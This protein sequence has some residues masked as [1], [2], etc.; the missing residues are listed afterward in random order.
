MMHDTKQPDESSQEARASEVRK[1]VDDVLDRLNLDPEADNENESAEES[2]GGAASPKQD[3]GDDT[4]DTGRRLA[5]NKRKSTRSTRWKGGRHRVFGQ[6]G[7]GR[8]LVFKKH[9][10]KSPTSCAVP[11]TSD[12]IFHRGLYYQNGDIVS[13]GDAEDGC[14]YYAQIR[15]FLTTEY[16]EHFAALNWL[17]PTV[18]APADGSFHAAFFVMGPVEDVPRPLDSM[19]FEQHCAPDYFT[20]HY[21]LTGSVPSRTTG[22]LWTSLSPRIVKLNL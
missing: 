7:R 12:F 17:I 6:K 4:D 8:R 20:D 14:T 1:L 22:Y 19:Q 13:I 9:V 3:A 21:P 10:F 15:G 2:D 5:V 11:V 16:C 18:E